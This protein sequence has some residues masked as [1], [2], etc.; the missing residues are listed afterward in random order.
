MLALDGVVFNERSRVVA[1]FE[2]IRERPSFQAAIESHMT[3]GDRDY[4][5]VAREE[6][7]ASV[8]Q[9]LRSSAP[10]NA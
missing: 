3:Q 2:R 1:W 10:Q 4:F 7:E 9:I 8:R 6:T 5:R